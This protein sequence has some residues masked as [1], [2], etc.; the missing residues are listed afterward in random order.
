[1]LLGR[2]MEDRI[3]HNLALDI[4]NALLET[5]PNFTVEGSADDY[6]EVLQHNE[7]ETYNYLHLKGYG[8]Y[9]RRQKWELGY[10]N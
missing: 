8:Y 2:T 7:F 4:A 6:Y 1:M 9:P 10:G 3:K 5:D